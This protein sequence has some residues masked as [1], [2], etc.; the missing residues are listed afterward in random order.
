[1]IIVVF[2][3]A[4]NYQLELAKKSDKKH[5]PSLFRATIDIYGRR[6]TTIGLFLFIYVGSCCF[7][8]IIP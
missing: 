5:R 1:M 3:R 8:A 7:T 4:W 2:H 6:Y